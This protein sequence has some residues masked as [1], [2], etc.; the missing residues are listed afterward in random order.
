MYA[1]VGNLIWFIIECDSRM[2]G[3]YGVRYALDHTSVG[4]VTVIGRK[5]LDISHPKLRQVLHRDFADCSELAQSLSGQ[6]AALFCLG[7]YTGAVPN[8]EF[9]KI[10]VDYTI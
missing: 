6:D 1:C 10:T 5:K 9:R 4:V 7:V 2:V 3:G 8:A